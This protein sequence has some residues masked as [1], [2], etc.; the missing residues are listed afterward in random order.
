MRSMAAFRFVSLLKPFT[1][2][3]CPGRPDIRW[4]QAGDQFFRDP[5]RLTIVLPRQYRKPLQIHH[6]S[7]DEAFLDPCTIVHHHLVN[8]QARYQPVIERV[9]EDE[10][11]GQQVRDD[12][13]TVQCVQ[14]AEI[15]W[16]CW[17]EVCGGRR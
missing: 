7:L 12:S 15:F 10:L 14:F 6:I 16:R 2:Q 3:R 9:D 8:V 1:S 17:G 13:S 11:R 5:A 4:A